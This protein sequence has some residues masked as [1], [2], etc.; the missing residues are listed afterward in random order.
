MAENK[1]KKSSQADKGEEV[2]KKDDELIITDSTK[3][4]QTEAEPKQSDAPEDKEL[5][6]DPEVEAS[7]SPESPAKTEEDKPAEAPTSTPNKKRFVWT[8]KKIILAVVAAIIVIMGVLAAIPATRYGIAG[9]F[10]KRDVTITL[11]DSKTNKPVSNVAIEAGGK[12]VMTD[13]KGMATFKAMPVGVKTFDI[14][15]KNYKSFNSKQTVD[16]FGNNPTF[17]L[18]IEATGRQVPVKV[19]NKVSQKPVE[20]ATIV[21]DGSSSKTDKNGEA[22]LVLPADKD[23]V[24][25]DLSSPGYNATK[26]IATVTEQ[27]DDKN[28]FSLV[29]AGKL[30]FLSKRSGT[31]DVLKS[32]LDGGNVQTV[33]KGTGKEEETDT[34]LLASRDWKYLALKSRRDSDTAKVYLISTATDKLAT[35]D[36]GSD[37]N[38]EL[39][40]WSGNHLIY[41]VGRGNVKPWE[42]K[43]SALK[44]YNATSA[45]LTTLDET[46]AVGNQNAYANQWFDSIYI[47]DNLLVY[48]KAW[49]G[50][51]SVSA[52]QH[53][54]ILSVKPDGQDKKTVKSFP[55]NYS[56]GARLYEP[57][58]VYFRA[59]PYDSATAKYEMYEYEDGQLKTADVSNDDFSKTYPTFLVSPS[60]M[61]TFWSEPRDGKNTL[62]V[63]DKDAKNSKQIATL[64]DYKPYGWYSEDYLL[65]SKDGSELYIMAVSDPS[66]VLKVTDY[67]KPSTSFAGYGYGYG[68]L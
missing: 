20:G 44:S 46:Q 23:T 57:Q 32:D 21:A 56:L 13:A 49:G 50:Y 10:V 31:I 53:P 34:I 40:G 42:P 27:K 37:I 2:A 62:F 60:G 36:E 24:D 12:T 22:V 15:K 61:K 52:G 9:L 54:D 5:H 6:K 43:G 30:Y 67:H 41:T 17:D 33:L 4:D 16:I 59:G 18:A 28:T 48:T 8:R 7:E 25:A 63:G 68:G 55:A 47:L 65:V 35:V 58:S 64:S 19:I 45:Q 29:P 51:S 14:Q 26:A 11:H 66:K 39:K 1:G 38:F 3:Q